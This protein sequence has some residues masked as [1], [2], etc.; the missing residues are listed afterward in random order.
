MIKRLLV[1]AL[2]LTWMP[3][4]AHAQSA[5]VVVATCGTPPATYSAGAN[6]QITQDTAG[7]LCTSA[8]ASGTTA[9]T[10]TFWQATQPISA[11]ALPLP[12]G[13]ATAAKQPALGTAGSSS[14]D[15]ITV[16]GVTSGT[17]LIVGGAVAAGASDSGNPVK[18]GGYAAST[19]PTA[20]TVGQRA[21]LWLGLPGNVI[22]GGQAATG[23]DNASNTQVWVPDATNGTA[24]LLGIAPYGYDGSVWGRLRLTGS[25]G[26]L[27]TGTMGNS[28]CHISTATTTTCK[29]GA[30]TL[31][32]LS[33]N[34]LGT[35]ASTTTVYDNTAGSGTVLAVINTLAGQTSYV[36]DIAFATGLT[37]VTTGTVAPDITVSYR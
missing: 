9:V 20:V 35:V 33:V 16:Q 26:G 30:G 12:S 17:P 21:N 7:K 36:Y 29:S 34:N 24:R 1:V 37:L 6:R 27:L 2:A 10:G 28:A 32:T 8:S 31:H 11:A 15:V 5:A 18:T 13:A 23:V 14:A 3:M 25:A 22:V 19:A 4:L